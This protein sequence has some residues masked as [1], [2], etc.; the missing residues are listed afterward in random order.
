ML[1]LF[2]GVYRVYAEHPLP[3]SQFLIGDYVLQ[4][5][6]QE[7]LWFLVEM[8]EI[9]LLLTSE[10]WNAGN[11]NIFFLMLISRNSLWF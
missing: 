10:R 1:K 4:D 5:T 9:M 3:K 8:K 7:L 6:E 2:Q 11:Q